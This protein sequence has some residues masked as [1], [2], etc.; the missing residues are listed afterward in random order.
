[1]SKT[2]KVKPILKKRN[3][4]SPI[5]P[6]IPRS[7]FRTT[8][9][10][11]RQ[12]RVKFGPNLVRQI[13]NEAAKM[14]NRLNTS[15]RADERRNRVERR[16]ERQQVN[17]ENQMRKQ[18]MKRVAEY[19]AIKARERNDPEDRIVLYRTPQVT[20]SQV[21]EAVSLHPW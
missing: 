14:D 6:K 12:T 16:K 8:S 19:A 7:P 13:S 18:Q 2:R 17:M 20:Q 3:P 21:T 4:N 15:K 9:K 5:V 10:S 11:P 1:M